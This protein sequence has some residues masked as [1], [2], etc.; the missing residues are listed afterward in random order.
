MTMIGTR[1]ILIDPDGEEMRQ[2]LNS[3]RRAHR[4]ERRLMWVSGALALAVV[5]AIVGWLQ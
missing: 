4:L 3:Y 1:T 2:T 5:L